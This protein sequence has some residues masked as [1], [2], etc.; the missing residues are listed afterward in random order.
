MR[1]TQ[2]DELLHNNLA[3]VKTNVVHDLDAVHR[4]EF[5]TVSASNLM[6]GHTRSFESSNDS[7][8]I[9]ITGL[10]V[11][12]IVCFNHSFVKFIKVNEHD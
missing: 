2:D 8:M 11:W 4:V 9:I 3:V 1:Q 12:T 5:D 7:L 6:N 10:A